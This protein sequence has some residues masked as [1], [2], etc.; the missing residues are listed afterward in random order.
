MTSS[1]NGEK[2]TLTSNQRQALILIE[3]SHLNGL[4]YDILMYAM[5]HPTTLTALVEARLIEAR[6][7]KFS[8]PAGLVVIRYHITEAGRKAIPHNSKG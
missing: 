1:T 3:A 4:S 8:K 7:H 6:K 2:L 5:I